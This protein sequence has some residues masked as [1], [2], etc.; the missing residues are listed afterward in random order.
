MTTLPSFFNKGNLCSTIITSNSKGDKNSKNF[1]IS[2]MNLQFAEELSLRKNYPSSRLFHFLQRLLCSSSWNQH[3]LCQS[4]GN[5]MC[6]C[7]SLFRPFPRGN[8]LLG[9]TIG[10]PVQGILRYPKN[11]Q[12]PHIG[13]DDMSMCHRAALH[14]N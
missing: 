12:S 7:L 8:P 13:I 10:Y 14:S 9:D 2:I 5:N 1:F 6:E 11:L 3:S 4:Q